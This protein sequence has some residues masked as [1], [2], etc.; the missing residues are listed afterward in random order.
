MSYILDALKRAE[1]KARKKKVAEPRAPE[2]PPFESAADAPA[3]DVKM[4]SPNRYERINL[5][6]GH[7]DDLAS[8]RRELWER[9]AREANYDAV[10]DFPP[11]TEAARSGGPFTARRFVMASLALLVLL[12]GATAANVWLWLRPAAV[13]TDLD[14]LTQTAKPESVLD[15]VKPEAALEAP[16]WSGPVTFRGEIAH[17]LRIEMK[18]VREGAKLW[19]SYYYERIGKDIPVR[20]T[21]DEAGAMVLEEFVKGQKTGI[22]MGKVVSAARIEG[23]WSKPGSTRSRDF[24]LMSESPLQGTPITHEQREEIS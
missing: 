15:T 9:I 20:G 4:V 7:E 16:R 23:K 12:A 10:P 22:F 6:A 1:Q 18:L 13:T 11:P 5:K 3:W 17:G 14:T 8:G 21:V 19:G 24:F 2:P